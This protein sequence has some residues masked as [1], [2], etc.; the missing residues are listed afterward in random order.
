M[1]TSAWVAVLQGSP[2]GEQVKEYLSPK[3]TENGRDI[4]DIITPMIVIMEMKSVYI[5][6]GKEDVFDEDLVTISL[7]GKLENTNID[8]DIAINSGEKHGRLHKDTRIGYNDCILLTLAEKKDM[9]VISTDEHYQGSDHAIYIKK[10][11]KL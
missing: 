7:A 10:E 2:E 8:I 4:V 11:G 6:Q 9:K 1:D 3:I 5:R